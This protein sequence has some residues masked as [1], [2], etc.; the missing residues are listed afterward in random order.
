MIDRDRLLNQLKQ[1][2]G[3]RAHAY[4]DVKQFTYGYGCRAPGKDA[5]IAE[6]EAAKLLTVHMEQS[7]KDFAKIFKGHEAK[8]NPVRAEAFVNM[9]F[10]MGPGRPDG[11]EGL[12]SFR[13]TL[14]LIFKNKEVPWGLVAD[15]L[16]KSLWFRQIGDS[17]APP[18]RGNRIIAEVRTGIKI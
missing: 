7:I 15:N 10:N 3:F 9:V 16:K 17:G 18:G 6:P 11:N 12:Q 5:S 4:W 1:D 2:E 13:N 8:F 14:A